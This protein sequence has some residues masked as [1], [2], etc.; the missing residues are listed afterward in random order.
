MTP[1][2]KIIAGE[3]VK[4]FNV[5][6]GGKIGSGGLRPASPLDVFCRPR[7]RRRCAVTSRWSF[8][9]TARGAHATGRG[10]RFSST[11]GESID[12]GKELQRRV[13][14]RL[15]PPGARPGPPSTTITWASPARGNRDCARSASTC[16]WVALP[17]ISC[18]VWLALRVATE[19]ATC[20][21]PRARMSSFRTCRR[22]C[23]PRSTAEPLLRELRH[24]P[25][26]P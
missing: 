19:V 16:R 8:A 25:S 10:W 7:T 22:A 4:G 21:L 24:D 13:G 23:S 1:A 11:H 5:A 14:D 9:T 20:G 17:R 15:L 2:I 3:E 18:S 26:G 12:F 6:V